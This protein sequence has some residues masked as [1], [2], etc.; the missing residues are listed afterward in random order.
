MTLKSLTSMQ[1][2]WESLRKK[3]SSSIPSSCPARQTPS[4][5]SSSGSS[6]PPPPDAP[7]SPPRPLYRQPA[8][9]ET[10][11]AGPDATGVDP[12][13]ANTS[14]AAAATSRSSLTSLTVSSSVSS[15][16]PV[17]QK[18]HLDVYDSTVSAPVTT[19]SSTESVSFAFCSRPTPRSS[20]APAASSPASLDAGDDADQSASTDMAVRHAR[21]GH[22][23]NLRLAIRTGSRVTASSSSCNLILSDSESDAQRSVSVDDVR[24]SEPSLRDKGA[25]SQDQ[26][27]G[28][29]VSVGGE[30]MGHPVVTSSPAVISRVGSASLCEEGSNYCASPS[31]LDVPSAKSSRS[32]SFD[33]ATHAQNALMS[34]QEEVRKPR[35]SGGLLEIPKW[36]MFIR[37]ASGPASSIAGASATI[38]LS[39]LFWKDCVHCVLLEEWNKSSSAS[40]SCSPPPS[41][42]GSYSSDSEDPEAGISRR[43]VS[44]ESLDED[45]AVTGPAGRSS[46]APSPIPLLTLSVAPDE[47]VDE[48]MEEDLG[49]G[50][51]VI[52]LEVPVL[53]KSGRS[54][55][56]DSS[57]L[58]V[59]RRT[60]IEDLETPPGKSN[61]SR[62]VDIALPVGV[63]GPYIIVP[64]EKP[65][66]VTTQ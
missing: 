20:P 17:R 59:P 2:I 38:I 53:P 15:S 55:S 48:V 4:R 32:K 49:N 61:R 44:G 31:E 12:I 66:P 25:T 10:P 63:D 46:K 19:F 23:Y 16:P 8:A 52:S 35:A 6:C 7:S 47:S 24:V 33:S 18:L 64:S 60:D 65:V 36:K 13:S 11:D 42:K 50:V 54:A 56:M 34:G 30:K 39:D 9:D 3:S 62:S 29:T 41:G 43:S 40:V 58:Q 22:R 14:A 45:E 51:T 28:A 27:P 57:Y 5:Q 21:R 26:D 1:K 37:R